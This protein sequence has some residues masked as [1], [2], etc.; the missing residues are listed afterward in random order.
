MGVDWDSAESVKEVVG[1]LFSWSQSKEVS[2][3]STP[4]EVTLLCEL[5]TGIT[6]IV[7]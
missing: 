7:I 2:E 1:K 6:I 4:E 3:C 5:I